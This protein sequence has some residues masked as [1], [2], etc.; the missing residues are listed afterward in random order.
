MAQAAAATGASTMTAYSW[1]LLSDRYGRKPVILT[2]NAGSAAA[3]LALGFAPAYKWAIAA[4]VI[5]GLL[6][7]GNA[8]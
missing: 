2:A 3:M 8:V 4:R 5:G 6:A 7:S 1:G